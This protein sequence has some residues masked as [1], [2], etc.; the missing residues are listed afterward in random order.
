MTA[1]N[2]AFRT[3]S[4]R[5]PSLSALRDRDAHRGLKEMAGAD[6]IVSTRSE[7]VWV[8]SP[9]DSIRGLSAR[10]GSERWIRSSARSA[11]ARCLPVRAARRQ[12]DHGPDRRRYRDREDPA[13]S[14]ALGG[15]AAPAERHDRGDN[16]G[17]ASGGL[18]LRRL[19]SGM[20]RALSPARQEECA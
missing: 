13:A 17:G 4:L 11:A 10:T 5:V 8:E 1:Y 18:A 19:G 16:R 9:G 2:P 20:S 3:T 6:K 14:R 15:G 7:K 12:A